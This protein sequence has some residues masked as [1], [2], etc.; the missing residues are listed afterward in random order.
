MT[1]IQKVTKSIHGI[2]PDTIPYSELMDQE[3]PV[4]LKGLVKDWALVKAGNQGYLKAIDYLKSFYN[5]LTVGTFLADSKTKGRFFYTPDFSG[6]NFESTRAPL[7]K[8]LD[9]ILDHID[10]ESPPITYIGSSTV[11][12]CLPGLRQENDL[13]FNHAM[14]TENPPLASIWIGSPS[15]VSAHYDLPNNIACCCVGKR[16]FTLFPPDQIANLYP[17]P[18][19][20]TPAGQVISLVDFS[21]PDYQK[22][23]RFREAEEVGQI[24]DLE[25]G[26]GIFYPS[27]WWHHVQAVS[28]FNVMINYWWNT[29]P[30]FMGT[31]MN[32]VKHALLSLRD[33]P[34]HEKRAWSSIL[35]YYIFQDSHIAREHIPESAWGEL[36]PIDD[37]MARHLRAYLMNRLNR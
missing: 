27:L 36:G 9:R 18:L 35:D 21:E 26:D 24:A 4:I 19:D 3:E 32:V 7:D 16:R 30:G 17:G 6:F 2:T 1:N 31:P 22:Y 13:V 34:D 33:R 10:E 37:A 29:S 12:A 20:P 25:P 28:P 14:F 5:N 8:M 23:P 11:D 15:V